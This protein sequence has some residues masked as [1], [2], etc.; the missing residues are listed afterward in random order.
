MFVEIEDQKFV[1]ITDIAQVRLKKGT[2]DKT[3]VEY[4]GGAVVVIPDITPRQFMQ[5]A[6]KPFGAIV[7]N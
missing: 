3:V 4:Q 1:G 5:L 7:G 6:S 2:T